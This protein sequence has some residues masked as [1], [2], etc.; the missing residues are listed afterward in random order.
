M[1]DR[2]AGLPGNDV[3]WADGGAGDD[4]ER[5]DRSAVV[6]LSKR[7]RVDINYFIYPNFLTF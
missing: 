7:H 6:T 2:L 1:M 4:G 5:A 3:E